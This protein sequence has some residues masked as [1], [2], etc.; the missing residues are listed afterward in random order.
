[1][2]SRYRWYKSIQLR[3]RWKYFK[4]SNVYRRDLESSHTYWLLFFH[5]SSCLI[6]FRYGSACMML[7]L[8]INYSDL[9]RYVGRLSSTQIAYITVAIRI[10]LAQPSNIE[11][12]SNFTRLNLPMKLKFEFRIS[13]IEFPW[14]RIIDHKLFATKDAIVFS[15][16]IL[17]AVA[18]W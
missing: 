17:S 15:Q 1:M 3:W 4:P 5:Y 14:G 16:N 11:V 7:T 6:S 13:L 9:L 8:E 18:L 10:S 2:T 12:C